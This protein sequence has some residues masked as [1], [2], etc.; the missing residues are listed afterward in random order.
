MS[1]DGL[2]CSA[3]ELIALVERVAEATG[4]LCSAGGESSGHLPTYFEL[5]TAMALCHFAIRQV[6][7]AV[8]EVGMGGRLDS[9]NVCHPAVTVITSISY[10]HT[11]HL[12]KT[13][14]AIAG[15]K[16]GIVKPGIPL[17]SGVTE[18]EPRDVLVEAA[19][20]AGAPLIELGRDFHVEYQPP[21]DID[22]RALTGLINYREGR[23]RRGRVLDSVPL[24]LLGAHQ[25]DNAAVALATIGRLQQSGWRLDETSLRR[26]LAQVTC[27]A[28][29]EV[30][31]R[32]PLVVIDVAHNLASIDALLQTLGEDLLRRR[33]LLVFATTRDKDVPGM[34]RRLLPRFDRVVLTRYTNN[35]RGVP[36]KEL[37]ELASGITD[38]LPT[39]CADPAS[40]W[41]EVRRDI[42]DDD[43]VCVTGSFFIAA[44]MRREIDRLPLTG[45]APRVGESL[46]AG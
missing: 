1:I 41:E 35:P 26:G 31:S 13:L 9:T 46:S 34:L 19:R 21:R 24:S 45:A 39:L 22:D 15:E 17:V 11:Q 40:A 12:G 32:R 27:P 28:R 16:A 20:R 42:G 8:L 14:A 29:V 33:S 6:D 23:D 36:T 2:P 44:E 10:D 4:R 25:A 3:T 37:E 38:T 30:V 7:V 18:T 43:L 5:T